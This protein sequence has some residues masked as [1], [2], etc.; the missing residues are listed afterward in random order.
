[1]LLVKLGFWR[2]IWLAWR[3]SHGYRVFIRGD[4][5]MTVRIRGGDTEKFVDTLHELGWEEVKNIGYQDS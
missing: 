2:T 5:W 4:G 3:A 1:V